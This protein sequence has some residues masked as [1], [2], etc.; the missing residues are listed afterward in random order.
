MNVPGVAL[1]VPEIIVI[2]VL[3]GGWLRTPNLSEEEAVGGRDGSVRKSVDE[4]L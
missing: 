2:E 3:V 1:P 4:F